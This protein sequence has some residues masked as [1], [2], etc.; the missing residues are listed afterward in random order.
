M[1]AYE[2]FSDFLVISVGLVKPWQ[3][4]VAGWLVT[5]GGIWLTQPKS[6]FEQGVCDTL[7]HPLMYVRYPGTG[8]YWQET[9][10]LFNPPRCLGSS[11]E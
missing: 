11:L 1:S 4:F 9:K 10:R 8:Q 7:L 2:A 6:M 3:R 5:S